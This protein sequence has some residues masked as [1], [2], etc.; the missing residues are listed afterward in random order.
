MT[1]KGHERFDCCIRKS[2]TI[3]RLASNPI[4]GIREKP[5]II[6]KPG[7]V[8]ETLKGIR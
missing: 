7:K 5:K 4:T 6:L 2:K 8:G 3:N 1:L